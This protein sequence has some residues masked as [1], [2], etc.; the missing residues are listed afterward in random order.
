MPT[1]IQGDQLEASGVTPDVYGD[2]THIPQLTID[3]AGRVTVASEVPIASVTLPF[4]VPAPTSGSGT[5]GSPYTDSD[6]NAAGIQTAIDALAAGRGGEVLL[7]ASRYNL[8]AA[9]GIV[10]QTPSIRLAG[11]AHGFNIDPNGQ[12]EGINGTKIRSTSDGIH[13]GASGQKRGG[14]TLDDL[15]LWGA[16]S[17]TKYAVIVDF[18]VDQFEMHRVK[19][20]GNWTYGF[21]C[22]TI[23]DACTI[24][25]LGVLGCT[26][27]VF[28]DTSCVVSYS[29]FIACE[30]DDNGGSGFVAKAEGD[31][32]GRWLRVLGC[33]LTRNGYDATAAPT[34]PC[35]LF[36]GVHESIIDSCAIR[37]A[38]HDL[39][40]STTRADVDGIIVEGDRNVISN[41]I[42]VDNS[43]YGLRVRGDYNLIVANTFNNNTDG[44]IIIESGATGNVIVAAANVDITDNGT[45]TVIITTGGGGATYP[46]AA[47][48]FLELATVTAGNAME[49]EIDTAQAYNHDYLQN[50][51]ADGDTYTIPFFLAAGTYTLAVLGRTSTNRGKQDLYVDNVLVGTLDWYNA[52][53]QW[54][55]LKTIG[56]VAVA[57]DGQHVL[58]S[59]V[60]GKNGSSTNFFLTIT[61]FLFK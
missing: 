18:A 19:V 6:D 48:M 10:I 58:K 52:I 17:G 14:I 33:T 3:D 23:L 25:E 27:G 11:V 60:N 51:A 55:I 45:D 9:G 59:V 20:G 57:T 24:Q 42:I 47:E 15:Y 54:N 5:E 28:L 36:L 50:T 43:G 53:T 1:H 49:I 37:D 21:Y 7:K 40:G 16:I 61:K 30:L 4:T 41:N 56:S 2:A 32:N 35:N 39:I 12:S 29:R 31:S 44:D 26:W 13:L 46:L 34:D 22:N 38:G 8:T